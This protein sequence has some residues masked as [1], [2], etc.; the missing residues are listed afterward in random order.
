MQR[1]SQGNPAL[2]HSENDNA[3]LG[4]RFGGNAGGSP[5]RSRHGWEPLRYPR[6]LKGFCEDSS[7]TARQAPDF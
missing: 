5:A 7:R 6:N 1:G 3:V 2:V 4:I